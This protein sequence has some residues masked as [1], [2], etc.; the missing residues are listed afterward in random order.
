MAA[1]LTSLTPVMGSNTVRTAPMKTSAQTVGNIFFSL[2]HDIFQCKAWYVFYNLVKT[3]SESSRFPPRLIASCVFLVDSSRKSVNHPVDTP[4]PQRPGAQ[5][6]QFEDTSII[7]AG[8]RKTIIPS[9]DRSKA[10]PPHSPSE[11]EA[12][13]SQGREV[14]VLKDY[15]HITRLKWLKSNF[16]H[17]FLFFSSTVASIMIFKSDFCYCMSSKTR[18]IFDSWLCDTSEDN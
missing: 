3:W 1:V 9:Q 15:V 12:S 17:D 14:F 11:Q 10:A 5:T 18:Y 4:S 7:P 13:A 16:F 2:S 6:E 8:P